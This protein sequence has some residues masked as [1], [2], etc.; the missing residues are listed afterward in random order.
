MPHNF[1]VLT[2]RLA[3]SLSTEHFSDEIEHRVSAC[4]HLGGHCTRVPF[5]SPV[6]SCGGGR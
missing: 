5:R 4:A 3:T 1:V 2:H 6:T